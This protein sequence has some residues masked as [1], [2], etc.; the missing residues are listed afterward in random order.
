MEPKICVLISST[1][2]VETFFILEQSERD[3]IKR[4]YWS[5]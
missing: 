2:V 3:L 5:P 4:V 1:A